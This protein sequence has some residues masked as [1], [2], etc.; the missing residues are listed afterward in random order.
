MNH[1]LHP[2]VHKLAVL[3]LLLDQGSFKAACQQAHLSQSAISQIVT[4]LESLFG[5]TLIV[6]EQGKVLP[7]AAGSELVKRVRPILDSLDE[8][9]E[10]SFISDLPAMRW[11]SF[12]TYESIAIDILPTF[13]RRLWERL[14][15]LEL[16]LRTARSDD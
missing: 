1:S 9:A 3:R 4:Q 2:H 6:R 15:N 14:P 16:Q 11:L 12:G 7:T 13:T 8:L 5:T 10:R